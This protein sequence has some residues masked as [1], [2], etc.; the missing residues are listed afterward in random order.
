MCTVYTL[1][2]ST[3]ACYSE[4]GQRCRGWNRAVN[5]CAGYL[6]SA[7]YRVRS[8]RSAKSSAGPTVRDD[9][10]SDGRP[11]KQQAL[12]LRIGNARNAGQRA[13]KTP[14][15]VDSTVWML[16]QTRRAIGLAMLLFLS[17]IIE[18]HDDASFLCTITC[19]CLSADILTLC[20]T[21]SCC[22]GLTVQTFFNP[23]FVVFTFLF[24]FPSCRSRRVSKRKRPSFLPCLNALK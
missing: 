3:V 23:L 16:T 24:S 10:G 13:S 12:A 21:E 1:Y 11:A 17:T 22:A 7:T 19:T 20:R 9:G 14:R 8:G 18:S 6:C 15:N 2:T 5:L 4:H